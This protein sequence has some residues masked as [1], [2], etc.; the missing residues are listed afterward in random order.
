MID[1]R[2]VVPAIPAGRRILGAVRRD[3]AFAAGAHTLARTAARLKAWAE[4][5][6]MSAGPVASA[7]GGR[8]LAAPEAGRTVRL[9]AVGAR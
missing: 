1:S 3:V 9:W 6:H 4:V 7:E 5:G 2:Q 8:K